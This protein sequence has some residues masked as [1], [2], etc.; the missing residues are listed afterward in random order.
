MPIWT[1]TLAHL[2]PLHSL[3][4]RPLGFWNYIWMPLM[5]LGFRGEGKKQPVVSVFSPP[6]KYMVTG[7]VKKW[8]QSVA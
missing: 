6:E 1:G 4:W 7:S 3:T 5:C 2:L 8:S